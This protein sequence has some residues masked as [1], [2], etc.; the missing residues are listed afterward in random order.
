MLATEQVIFTK[1]QGIQL[2]SQITGKYV[3][4]EPSTDNGTDE[5]TGVQ[6]L[7]DRNG[8]F[9]HKITGTLAL[10]PVEPGKSGAQPYICSRTPALRRRTAGC[11]DHAISVRF[12]LYMERGSVRPGE[13]ALLCR[14]RLCPSRSGLRDMGHA[15]RHHQRGYREFL[16]CRE[17]R[18]AVHG[19]EPRYH[20]K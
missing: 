6:F 18:L 9:G 16:C 7:G 14:A 12:E 10:D 5:V 15:G 11:L 2:Y 4:G 19:I 3:P 20:F 13:R 17:R 8:V 1:Q